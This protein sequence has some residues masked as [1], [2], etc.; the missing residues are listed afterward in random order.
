MSS[1]RDDFSYQLIHHDRIRFSFRSLHHRAL[2]GVEG[3]FIAGFELGD[4]FGGGGERE[5]FANE[6]FDFAGVVGLG[7]AEGG[8]DVRRHDAAFEH[9]GEN[10]L[11][12]LLLRD[13]AGVDQ[14]DERGDMPRRNS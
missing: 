14:G 6:G 9:L 1:Q 8:H 13:G 3:L 12:G 5:D 2:E 7:E 4:G 11:F 10:G